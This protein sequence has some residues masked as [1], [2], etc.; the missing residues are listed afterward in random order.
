MMPTVPDTATAKCD[1]SPHRIHPC[2]HCVDLFE[3]RVR[4]KPS[5]CVDRRVEK[6]RKEKKRKEKK[7][8]GMG[9]GVEHNT[10]RRVNGRTI[11]R[12][13]VNG[14]EELPFVPKVQPK[15]LR[16]LIGTSLGAA[17]C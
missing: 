5:R 7:R 4:I 11:F 15:K 17:P 12:Q 6:K 10:A 14:T 9:R 13:R 8:K 2:V 3:G 1:I 16:W